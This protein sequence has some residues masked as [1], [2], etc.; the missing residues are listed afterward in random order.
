MFRSLALFVTQKSMF[1]IGA[2]FILGHPVYSSVTCQESIIL[3]V[4]LWVA[5]IET[6]FTE[7]SLS[8][9]SVLSTINR[10]LLCCNYHIN[11]NSVP[12]RVSLL[13]SWIHSYIV[14]WKAWQW[15]IYYI[16]FIFVAEEINGM[17]LQN[18]T[19]SLIHVQ[20][21]TWTMHASGSKR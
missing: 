13:Y 2:I 7:K 17:L 9:V 18:K 3:I 8:R 20:V 14:S 19:F 12:I 1:I 15:Y 11:Y 16:S 21:I 6:R 10:Q 5:M 4:V